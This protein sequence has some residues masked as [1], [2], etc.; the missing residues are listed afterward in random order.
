MTSN[1]CITTH[2]PEETRSLGERIGA[3]LRSGICI[4]LRGPL[5][6]GKTQ[7][8]KGIATGCG[9]PNDVMV[10]S[11]T[12]VIINEYPGRLCVHHI[13]AYRLSGGDELVAL[14]FEEMV[15]SGAVVIVEWA[16]RVALVVPED[17][18]CVSLEHAGDTVRRI[19]CRATGERSGEVVVALG[20]S[21]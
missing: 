8:V 6:A 20:A 4:A 12:F 21:S 3:L 16:D 15:Q 2:S 10:N 17:H 7:L 1:F 18:L 13:D 14:G 19:C 9:V 5:G 11:P